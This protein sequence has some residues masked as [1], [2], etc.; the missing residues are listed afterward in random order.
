MKYMLM[1]SGT[2]AGFAEFAQWPKETL[3]AHIAFMRTVAQEL[4]NEGAFVAAEGL[5]RRCA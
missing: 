3:Q 2:K 4:K 5:V 1:M